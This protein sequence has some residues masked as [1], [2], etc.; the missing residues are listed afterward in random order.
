LLRKAA[1]KLTEEH[2]VIAT[3]K[4]GRNRLKV[5][6]RVFA[7]TT[8][9]L[10]DH[11]GIREGMSCLDAGCG[12]GDITSDLAR[13]VGPGGRV[14]G[15]D[16]DAVVLDIARQEAAAQH[17]D[18]IEFRVCE[19]VDLA[20]SERFDAVYVRF[21]LS[22]LPDAGSALARMFRAL[23]PGGV[24]V[25]EDVEFSAH[26]CFPDC[27]AFADYVRLYSQAARA[28]SADPDIGPRLPSLLREA[29]LGEIDMCVVQ[30][31]GIRGE[32]KFLSAITMEMIGEAVVSAGLTSADEVARIVRRARYRCRRRPHGAEHAA[33]RPSVGP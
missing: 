8:T 22:H 32:V 3:G 14:V 17:L 20:D 2:Y 31:A 26:F 21:L 18:N 30:P 6:T 10:L 19:V 28:R 33:H 15:I 16:R 29:G 13:R 27:P 7:E 4:K 11:V 5:L 9:R 25:V 23:R 24:L 12:G 1:R